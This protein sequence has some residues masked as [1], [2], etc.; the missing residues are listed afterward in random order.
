M[1][2]SVR[3]GGIIGFRF[4]D[5]I[6]PVLSVG[7]YRSR[8]GDPVGMYPHSHPNAI[9]ICYFV[10]GVVEWWAEDEVHELTPHDVFVTLP[11]VSH[12]TV[13][14]ALSPCEYLWVHLDQEF[15]PPE[16]R[17]M[18][19]AQGLGGLHRSCP[20]IGGMVAEL[21]REHQFQDRFS[22]R[23]CESL[24]STLLIALARSA[25]KARRQPDSEL[26][27]QAK[28]AL[29]EE[30]GYP[31]TVEQVADRLCVSAVWLTKKFRLEVGQTPAAWLAASKITQAKRLLRLSDVEISDIAFRLEFA[32][33]QYFATAFRRATGRSPSEYRNLHL[34]STA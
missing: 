8:V 7:L 10:R 18:A 1:N 20:E 27:A 22:G 30:T 31:P 24:S 32:S 12:G 15:V 14:S 17:P 21:F 33:S 6:A 9:E 23:Q 25:D 4:P 2:I 19:D 29:L 26:V 3:S 34:G 5:V 28:V 13:D 16:L 11:R